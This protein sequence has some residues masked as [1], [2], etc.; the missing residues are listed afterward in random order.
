MIKLQ[1]NLCKKVPI[2]GLAYSSQSYMAGLEVEVAEGA[3]VEIIHA[4]LRE[5]YALLA[6]SVDDEIAAGAQSAELASPHGNGG[7]GCVSASTAGWPDPDTWPHT[8]P[9]RHWP[10]PST[11]NEVSAPRSTASPASG[12]NGGHMRKATNAQVKAIFG[13][14]KSLGLDR[15]AILEHVAR[16]GAPR[17]EDL[18]LKNASNLIEELRQQE[19]A[20]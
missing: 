9:A 10:A 8:T 15:N 14:G 16:F 7:P 11:G 1:A 18:T 13:I 5:V 3:S 2:P 4:R 20:A 19:P 12:R 17:P 6:K